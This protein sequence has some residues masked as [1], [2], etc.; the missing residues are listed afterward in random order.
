M[1]ETEP[2]RELL[3]VPKLHSKYLKALMHHSLVAK[4]LNGEYLHRKKILWE[5]YMGHLNNPDDL[6]KYGLE[7]FPKK[8]NRLDVPM[9]LDGDTSLTNLLLK[10]AMHDEI[11]DFCKS[12][13]KE[14]NNRVWELKTFVDYERFIKGGN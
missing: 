5:Y 3:K 9:Y 14:L 11:V 1:D 13:I 4:K 12:I 7:P 8:V 10:K 6:T 2:G